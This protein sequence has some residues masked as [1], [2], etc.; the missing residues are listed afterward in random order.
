MKFFLF[1][2]LILVSI[3]L[4]SSATFLYFENNTIFNTTLIPMNL[5][6]DATP[7][8]LSLMVRKGTGIIVEGDRVMMDFSVVPNTNI[9]LLF[10]TTPFDINSISQSDIEVEMKMDNLTGVL[11]DTAS[12][13]SWDIVGSM[14]HVE[15]GGVIMGAYEGYSGVSATQPTGAGNDY[16]RNAIPTYTISTSTDFS[17]SFWTKSIGKFA[18]DG[19]IDQ[20]QTIIGD[21]YGSSMDTLVESQD[22]INRG[23]YDLRLDESDAQ[24]SPHDT[25]DGEWHYG[26]I[27]RDFTGGTTSKISIYT[28]GQEWFKIISDTIS[29]TDDWYLGW[30]ENADMSSMHYFNGTLDEV[31]IYSTLLTKEQI[32]NMYG[33]GDGKYCAE[34]WAEFGVSISKSEQKCF[35][36]DT[37][38]P[39]LTIN[40]PRY[41][42]SDGFID[43]TGTDTATNM[44][45]NVTLD[46]VLIGEFINNGTMNYINETVLDRGEHNLTI[47]LTDSAGHIVTK[48]KIFDVLEIQTINIHTDNKN[49]I[50]RLFANF[51]DVIIN[52]FGNNS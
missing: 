25:L 29:T 9:T 26:V 52:M 13:A 18:P 40:T 46:G 2:F 21:K 37:T 4:T 11:N 51:K 15:T 10:R 17:V 24:G 20:R 31:R 43:I 27:V 14:N 28:D 23:S 12:T 48:E 7:S 5:S 35:I 41:E 1:I 6:T 16:L 42:S 47:V 38:D 30:Q 19:D 49:L 22:R 32:F 33:F 39:I 45:M 34:A 3:N 50:I 36:R 8:N 44:S